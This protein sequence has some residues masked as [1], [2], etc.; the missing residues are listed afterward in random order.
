MNKTIKLLFLIFFSGSISAQMNGTGD[1]DVNIFTDGESNLSMVTF[2]IPETITKGNIYLFP[3]WVD[4][5]RLLTK[6]DKKY[7]IIGLNYNILSGNFEIKISKDSIFKL[8]SKYIKQI[9][10]KGSVFKKFNIKGNDNSFVEVLYESE[11]ILFLKKFN[12][13]LLRGKFNPLDGTKSPDRYHIYYNFYYSKNGISYKIRLNKKNILPLFKEK[14]YVI[15]N[16]VKKNKLSFKNTDDLV[17]IFKFYE[18]L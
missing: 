12:I 13:R 9:N 14:H 2:K 3:K 11:N 1:E 18:A 7:N 5:A 15:M 4:G 16:D 10:V 17:K 8:D 6:T